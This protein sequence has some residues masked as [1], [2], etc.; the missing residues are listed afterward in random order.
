MQNNT[1]RAVLTT[2]DQAT[3]TRGRARHGE[4]GARD[5]GGGSRQGLQLTDSHTLTRNNNTL[6]ACSD[7][8]NNTLSAL[9]DSGGLTTQKNTQKGEKKI[10]ASG[11]EPYHLGITG[12][13]TA[14]TGKR[15]VA[16]SRF[17]AE[18]QTFI[19]QET[20]TVILP[21]SKLKR[22]LANCL[23]EPI[24]QDGAVSLHRTDDGTGASFGGLQTC[25]IRYACAPCA[26]RISELARVKLAE[27]I[28]AVRELGGSVVMVTPTVRHARGDRVGDVLGRSRG[29]TGQGAGFIG[30]HEDMTRNRPYRALR[31]SHGLLHSIKA[32]ECT[33]GVNG[34][35]PHAHGLLFSD[36]PEVDAER[37]EF[38]MYPIWRDAA[39]RFGLDTARGPG[40]TVAR[41]FGEVEDYIAKWGYPK[42][43]PTWGV[44][45]EIAKG[46]RKLRRNVDGS[47][48][49]YSP[50]E[51][52]REISH[53]GDGWHAAV[54]REHVAASGHKAYLQRSRGLRE[55]LGVDGK[56]G[57]GTPDRGKVWEV[58]DVMQWYAV[59]W[60][61]ERARVLQL[62]RDGD[63]VAFWAY[64]DKL[65][66]EYCSES[67]A[68]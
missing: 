28:A 39:A 23:K 58:L 11:A 30:A 46:W 1:H 6:S 2:P 55:W 51:L 63:R 3:A 42:D 52:L 13:L 54:F 20:A 53:N 5:L 48:R 12:K 44:E 59:R 33:Y 29:R 31:A 67:L 22:R 19:L 14:A 36:R 56:Q 45:S 32:I 24:K 61:G 57:G 62:V 18:L 4:A 15:K 50:W 66:D 7:S 27:E 47:T 40:L 16:K 21:D 41:T 8:E 68:A 43:G 60:G 64:I 17:H 26:R 10:G 38:E 9:S 35:H 34:P 25:R 49:G 37:L 65:Y